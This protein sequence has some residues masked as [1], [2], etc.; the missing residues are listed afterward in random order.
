MPGMFVSIFFGAA[1]VAG[2][3]CG[4]FIP[5]MFCIAGFFA[6]VE[7]V[8]RFAR[9]RFLVLWVADI[10]I[11]GIF[12]PCMLSILCFLAVDFFLVVFLFFCVFAFPIF[13][14]GMFCM[15]CPAKMT[16]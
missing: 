7:A 4:I 2:F 9:P 12:M 6:A 5:G 16:D 8:L 1:V 15:S 14:P 3:C 10:F 11:P 13:I